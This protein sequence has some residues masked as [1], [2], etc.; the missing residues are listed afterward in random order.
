MRGVRETSGRAANS[1]NEMS[2]W[3]A[4]KEARPPEKIGT[5]GLCG[6]RLWTPGGI[7]IT[8]NSVKH[9]S[10]EANGHAGHIC[11]KGMAP[12]PEQTGDELP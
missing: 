10:A 7:F 8:D 12:H 3:E 1:E 4:V 5:A 6:P 2:C 11:W 9:S